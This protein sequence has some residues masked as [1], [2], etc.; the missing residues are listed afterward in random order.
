MKHRL[1]FRLTFMVTALLIFM[2]LLVVTIFS[3]FTNRI[4]VSHHQEVI[5][6]GVENVA[7]TFTLELPPDCSAETFLA[8]AQTIDRM[9]YGA[10]LLQ[11]V[12]FYRALLGDANDNFLELCEDRLQPIRRDTLP[13]YTIQVLHEALEGKTCC[14]ETLVGEEH[15]LTGGA[16]V[17]NSAG[18]VVGVLLLQHR[19]TDA[20]D[21]QKQINQVLLAGASVSLL[22]SV[23]FLVI[24]SISFTRPIKRIGKVAEQLAC[25]NLDARTHLK[26]N[27][28]VGQ[29]AASMD[30]LARQLEEA[31]ARQE[32]ETQLRN[33]F[34]SDISHD[35]KTP[36]T[37][38]CGSLEALCDEVVAAPDD[39]AAYHR[40]MLAEG[41]YLQKLIQNL[42]ELTRLKNPEFKSREESVSLS[43]LMGDAAMS[44]RPMAETRGIRFV[45][46]APEH[47]F[48]V[49]GDYEQLRRLLML[50]LDNAVK[51]TPSGKQIFFCQE[52]SGTI[53]IEDQ[54]RGI[55]PEQLP[56]IFDR[57]FRADQHMQSDSAGLGLPIAREIAE[58]HH[59]QIQV[60][61]SPG[62]GTIFR[63]VFE[64]KRL[65]CAR[66]S[67]LL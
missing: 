28:E 31:R 42:L 65:R 67:S 4:L 24:M 6:D 53:V 49:R 45:C 48:F 11:G 58:R 47:E 1:V 33:R 62:E 44:A 15:I 63:L 12:T 56:Y 64:A 40:Q 22:I 54:G 7:R 2:A 46:R 25:G 26:S 23:V 59:I 51:Y 20:I 5:T 34:L 37:V 29:L 9:R 36:V 50:I 43:E 21:M 16:P 18:E 55:A 32:N 35:L 57:Y 61:S 19:S 41:R 8:T 13:S 30:T 3:R 17:R 39:V 27:D 52:A 14:L 38:I 66:S 10:E 60:E